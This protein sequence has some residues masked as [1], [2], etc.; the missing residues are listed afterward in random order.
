MI[1]AKYVIHH[2]PLPWNHE[3]L[4]AKALR[5]TIKERAIYNNEK[6]YYILII[7]NIKLFITIDIFHVEPLAYI[8]YH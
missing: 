2:A 7:T 3:I 1:I 8:L 5:I 6:L 4:R